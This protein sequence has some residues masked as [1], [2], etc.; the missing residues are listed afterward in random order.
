MIKEL[1]EILVPASNDDM[2]FTYNHHKE[3]DAV[4][5]RKA[6]GV[7]IMKIAKGQ[8]VIPTGKLYVDKMIP[9]RIVCDEEQIKEII[10][11]TIVHYKQE[12]VLAYRISDKVILHHKN[13]I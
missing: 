10:D 5:K 9:C 13:D 1:W 8:W 11:F 6:G 2:K 4:V 7:T 3:W 12:A